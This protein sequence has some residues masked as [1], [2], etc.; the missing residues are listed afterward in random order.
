MSISASI[1]SELRRLALEPLV[2]DQLACLGDSSRLEEAAGMLS[3]LRDR[4]GV[5]LPL[6]GGVEL[7]GPYASVDQACDRA[8]AQAKTHL[9]VVVDEM[10]TD[11]SRSYGTNTEFYVTGFDGPEAAIALADTARWVA[12]WA[13]GVKQ[14]I[15]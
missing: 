12:L 4:C 11:E 7:G 13:R 6:P 5:Q 10:A 14:P 8:A 3:D 15:D 9:V 1:N 2:E